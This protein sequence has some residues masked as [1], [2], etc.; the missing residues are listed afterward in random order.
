MSNWSRAVYHLKSLGLLYFTVSATRRQF[1][2]TVNASVSIEVLDRVSGLRLTTR[3]P[4]AVLHA[5]SSGS[6]FTDPVLFTA[7]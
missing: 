4:G 7:R 6:L 1:D 3:R 2:V 5:N